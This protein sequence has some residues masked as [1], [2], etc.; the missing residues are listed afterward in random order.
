M[1][2]SFIT[3]EEN[4]EETKKQIGQTDI[5]ND[6]KYLPKNKSVLDLKQTLEQDSSESSEN[7]LDNIYIQDQR[8]NSMQLQS[9]DHDLFNT[10]LPPKV[11]KKEPDNPVVDGKKF[12]VFKETAKEEEARI[13][14][15]SV[16][17]NL[18]TWKLFRIM[19]KSN[20][21][22]RQDQFAIQ[23]ISQI[24]SIFKKKKLDLW[25]KPYEIVGTGQ[26]SGI[27]EFI[28]DSMAISGI[29]EKLGGRNA[30]LVHYFTN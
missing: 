13:R 27:L 30:R 23:L 5:F 6:T 3:A 12:K 28:E 19:V 24:D 25:L 15:N 16:F 26:R 17:G 1:E 14:K 9:G 11:F 21:E 20:D 18:V 2:Q 29:K 10:S 22:V 8:S 4:I 7:S